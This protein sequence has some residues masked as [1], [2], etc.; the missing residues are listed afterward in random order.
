MRLPVGVDD[1][2]AG[3]ALA[4]GDLIQAVEQG[5]QLVVLDP[6]L[7]P[8]G[9]D[10]VE[11]HQLVLHPF[12]ERRPLLRPRREVEDDG[13]GVCG[14]VLRAGQL[15]E[16]G[17]LSGPRLAEDQQLS[18]GVV[19]HLLDVSVAG[20]LGSGAVG[21]ARVAPN[22]RLNGAMAL[23]QLQLQASLVV[24]IA[25]EPFVDPLTA[26]L[27]EQG[28]AVA[29]GAEDVGGVGGLGCSTPASLQHGDDPEEHRD[30]DA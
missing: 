21:A 4:A 27:G 9:R 2:D 14:V 30:Q 10:A 11:A 29:L 23:G 5:Q 3:G 20:D 25:L 16:L 7:G 13:D 19:K 12:V 15:D 8:L 1:G 22:P 17:G 18:R 6:L 24:E 26:G 28:G